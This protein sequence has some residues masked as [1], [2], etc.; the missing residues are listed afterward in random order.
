MQTLGAAPR[1]GGNLGYASTIGDASLRVPARMTND[2]GVDP[3]IVRRARRRYRWL[4]VI[5]VLLP[6]AGLVAGM[7]LAGRGGH[8]LPVLLLVVGAAAAVAGL[9]TA[10]AWWLVRRRVGDL[11]PTLWGADRV[12]RKRVVRALKHGRELTGQDRVLAIAVARRAARLTPVNHVIYPLTLVLLTVSLVLQL[13]GRTRVVSLVLTLLMLV[14]FG[15]LFVM[16]E[17]AN[18]RAR[19]YLDRYDRPSEPQRATAP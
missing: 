11:T 10:G 4:L 17:I 7:V 16:V 6:A 18:R 19:R 8:R 5:V 9:L 12:T 1:P 15:A 3:E 2:T 14:D 13:V